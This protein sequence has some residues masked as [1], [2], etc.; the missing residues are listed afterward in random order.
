MQWPVIFLAGMGIGC[1]TSW[2][3]WQARYQMVRER[4]KNDLVAERA[5]MVEQ[6]HSKDV[7][8]G[9][10]RQQINHLQTG[11]GQQQQALTAEAAQRA[12]AETQAAQAVQLQEHIQQLQMENSQLTTQLTQSRTRLQ[13]QQQV[14]DEK[15]ALLTQARDRMFE[16]FKALSAEALQTNNET[17]LNLAQTKLGQFHTQSSS[18]LLQRQQAIDGLVQPLQTSLT[19]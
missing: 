17:F 14:S 15:L 9:E 18:E 11:L 6:L 10:L 19:K 8:L 13:T 4:A 1:L 2:L 12:V 16:A 5:T 7:Q 3:V